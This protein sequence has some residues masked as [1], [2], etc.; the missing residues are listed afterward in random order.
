MPFQAASLPLQPLF[1]P[2]S[3]QGQ[4]DQVSV[5]GFFVA[6]GQGL[7]GL[8]PLVAPT[9]RPPTPADEGI[10][11]SP[12][13][14][15]SA[16]NATTAERLNWVVCVASASV[17]YSTAAREPNIP[18]AALD[19]DAEIIEGPNGYSMTLRV[20]LTYA[21]SFPK[22][23][24]VV[25]LKKRQQMIN[26][27]K[28]SELLLI[29][30]T[31]YDYM[32]GRWV[33]ITTDIRYAEEA[34]AVVQA[35]ITTNSGQTAGRM[36]TSG[37][38]E[39][40]KL[41][42]VGEQGRIVL[43][44]FCQ[45]LYSYAQMA[46]PGEERA[47]SRTLV[48]L[49]LQLPWSPCDSPAAQCRL[50]ARVR[51]PSGSCLLDPARHVLAYSD[52][53]Q[54]C[55]RQQLRT[56]MI[57]PAPASD[58]TA[59]SPAWAL[60]RET[61]PPAST[62]VLVWLSVPDSP[63]GGWEEVGGVLPSEQ[64]AR[65]TLLRS[66][67]EDEALLRA[68][69]PG[70]Q[71]GQLV[72]CLV[73]T[74]PPRRSAKS[75]RV[76]TDITISDASGS[77]R[78]SLRGGGFQAAGATVRS[79]FNSVEARRML[80][81]LQAIP[82][83]RA[84]GLLLP[85]D[86]WRQHFVVFDH[87]VRADFDL[88]TKVSDLD[89]ATVAS[90]CRALAEGDAAQQAEGA[91]ALSLAGRDGLLQS[92]RG[93]LEKLH[94]LEPGG[95]TSFVAGATRARERYV[96]QRNGD[97]AD[98]GRSPQ[99]TAY[100]NFDTDGG[101]NCG[102]CF[103]AIRQLVSQA[104]VVQGHV[105]GVGSWVDQDCAS[106]V[107]RLL[108]G[109]ASLALS[110]PEQAAADLLLRQDLSRWVRVWRSCPLTVATS[111]GA[112]SWAAR[113]G[114][115]TENAV[116]CL[117]AGGA[118]GLRFEA[119][120][121]SEMA[122]TK[123]KLVGLQAGESVLLYLLSRVPLPV[124]QQRLRVE[125]L[126]A[127]DGATAAVTVGAEPLRGVALGH[128]WLAALGGGAS[129]LVRN[130][131]GLCSRL[132]QRLEDDLSFAWNLPTKSGSTAALGR[133][134][135]QS[136]PPVPSAQQPEEPRLPEPELVALFGGLGPK[137][138]TAQL[139]GAPMAGGGFRCLP[140]G[141]GGLFGGGASGFDPFGPAGSGSFSA[142]GGCPPMGGA[143]L[144]LACAMPA[145]PSPAGAW[146]ELPPTSAAMG[147]SR[148]ARAP[149]AGCARAS[150]EQAEPASAAQPPG[151]LLRASGF[152]RAG[153]EKRPEADI[154]RCVAA[155]KYLARS[156][157]GGAAQ[158]PAKAEAEDPLVA[159]LFGQAPAPPAGQQGGAHRGFTCDACGANPIV[160]ARFKASNRADVDVCAPCRLAGRL[161]GAG[162]FRALADAH[163]A[164][165]WALAALLEWW[166]LAWAAAGA[167]PP[168]LPFDEGA[169]A[170]AAAVRGL[171][172]ARLRELAERLPEV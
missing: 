140:G 98:P 104:D 106:K 55:S 91:A 146:G 119:P 39:D 148:P 147:T 47:G 76:H 122:F 137:D 23:G 13:D 46:L 24:M 77:T 129:G 123:A 83:L 154:R 85:G 2:A 149:A 43:T 96:R 101:N 52:L 135:T 132:S 66:S 15:T 87:G 22:E 170:S 100:V 64:A 167:T 157:A 112:E 118:D 171:A 44:Y 74:A 7:A 82:L 37:A 75:A 14:D 90:L 153:P 67:A 21:S 30:T 56:T 105:L 31:F 127:E 130:G 36:Q 73:E 51:G 72:R 172:P 116:E 53:N 71:V 92:W 145:A 133:A 11:A 3:G 88:E 18:P 27:E 168:A 125:F 121:V 1:P 29:E 70:G 115:R 86:L 5:P 45:E 79:S 10:Q 25:W 102:P 41:G 54:S 139:G 165:R 141:G 63:D 35:V 97:G 156:H 142:P 126:E 20:Q 144:G 59:D 33:P 134:R 159:A 111:A 162:G 84:R 124:L 143:P 19:Y 161:A 109:S 16:P 151:Q 107:A 94:S 61:L 42:P 4:A 113:H 49:A 160:G 60:S 32:D 110:F 69:L 38:V 163:E 108:K 68:A 40:A 150:V 95:A 65:A 93:L 164:L 28:L 99:H 6:T 26:D 131:T 114:M 34:E 48:P 9:W 128:H 158:A 58:A 17:G 169:L 78:M 8:S 120:D 62:A 80:M 152:M 155:L 81:R 166:P 117:L 89:D 50:G 103:D 138:A 57:V 136:R 12:G